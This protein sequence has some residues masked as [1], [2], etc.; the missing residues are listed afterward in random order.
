MDIGRRVQLRAELR[1]LRHLYGLTRDELRFMLNPKD[2]F[3]N[4]FPSDSFRVLKD[5]EIRD[6]GE[7]RTQRLVLAALTNSQNR[8]DLQVKWRNVTQQLNRRRSDRQ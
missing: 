8:S 7:Y 6:Y 2:S 4:D 1:L 3:G 5:R